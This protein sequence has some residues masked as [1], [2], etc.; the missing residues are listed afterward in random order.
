M[1]GWRF[2]KQSLRESGKWKEV[3]RREVD[4][5]AGFVETYRLRAWCASGEPDSYT[6][7]FAGDCSNSS[8]QT[9]PASGQAWPAL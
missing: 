7:G 6:A 3:G 2:L 9:K 4:G 5:Q 8:H 1:P